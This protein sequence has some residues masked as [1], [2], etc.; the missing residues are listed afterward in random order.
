MKQI[1]E[2]IMSSYKYAIIE[3]YGEELNVDS[4]VGG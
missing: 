1:K 4:K 3:R 2:V